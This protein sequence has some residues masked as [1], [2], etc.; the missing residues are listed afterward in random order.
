MFN[1]HHAI[2]FFLKRKVSLDYVAIAARALS[3]SMLGI[4]VP[5]YI[6]TLGYS[7]NSIILYYILLTASVGALSPF[8]TKLISKIGIKK[9]IMISFPLL[10]IFNIALFA[11]ENYGINIFWTLIP[12]I[13][14]QMFFW[15]AFHADF[16]KNI[17]HKKTGHEIGTITILS[18]SLKSIGPILSA[19]IIK[20]FGFDILFIIVSIILLLALIPLFLSEEKYIKSRFS[21]GDLFRKE[22]IKY[23]AVF[24]AEG[25]SRTIELNFWPLFIFILLKD[26]LVVGYAGSLLFIAV[27]F[28]T[29]LSASYTD[30]N[31]K[32]LFMKIGSVLYAGSWFIR[33]IVKTF[34]NLL[35]A[36]FFTGIAQT[37]L[38]I[39]FASVFYNKLG[40]KKTTEYMVFRE[41]F[42]A[43]GGVFILSIL[44]FTNSFITVFL[45]LA[46]A[47]I[48]QGSYR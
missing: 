31:K 18:L 26:F 42:T 36:T 14:S 33:T 34:S 9:S 13:L 32:Y 29:Y 28:T 19:F 44:F 21:F 30:S 46:F 3:L 24:F 47:A 7:L 22:H 17:D 39:P 27:I 12:L 16:S 40:K 11:V 23:Y 41:I 48:I 10:I 43:L 15:F 35:G 2:Q 1:Y 38:V 4:F 5:I 45:I 25:A 37:I 6:F 8:A 20:F